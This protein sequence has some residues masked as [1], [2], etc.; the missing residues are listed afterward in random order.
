MTRVRFAVIRLCLSLLLNA[1]SPPV[2]AEQIKPVFQHDLSN[3]AGKALTVVEVDFAAGTKAGAHRHGQAFV[4]AYVLSGT[5]RS[6]LAGE[7]A[8]TYRT[9]EGWSEPPGARHVLT[10]N[11][12]RTASARLLV[13]F[14]ANTGEPLKTPDRKGINLDA[15]HT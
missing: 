6:Q 9:G 2:L 13:T 14:I 8:R 7:P 11:L 12:S 5:I 1:A 15:Q 3:V 4:Y 10:E